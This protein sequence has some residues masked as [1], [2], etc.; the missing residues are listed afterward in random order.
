MQYSSFVLAPPDF[1]DPATW[2]QIV[3]KGLLIG[4]NHT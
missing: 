1:W 4:K 3:V 2:F